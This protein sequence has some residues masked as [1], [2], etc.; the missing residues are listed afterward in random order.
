MLHS[1]HEDSEEEE[2]P[3]DVQHIDIS[4]PNEEAE[5]DQEGALNESEESEEEN[6]EKKKSRLFHLSI[7]PGQTINFHIKFSPKEV[8]LYK[9]LLPLTLNKYGTL[10]GL[11][12]FIICRGLKPK[13][14]IEPQFCEFRRK[15]ISSP[16]KTYPSIIEISLSNPDKHLVKWKLDTSSINTEKIYSFEP[17][18]GE[19]GPG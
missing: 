3:K 14:L 16:D 2:L 12:R 4:N 1:V 13:F 7:N 17:S 8:R 15:I 5:F 9:F 19:V 11:A 6:L 10:P 18:H